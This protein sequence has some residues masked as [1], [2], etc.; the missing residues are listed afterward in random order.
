LWR[1]LPIPSILWI[2]INL[3]CCDSLCACGK[4]ARILFSKSIAIQMYQTENTMSWCPSKE[5]ANGKKMQTI[6]ISSNW[7]SI[8]IG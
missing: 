1:S 2:V 7:S 8:D 5:I 4:W 3:D 6:T